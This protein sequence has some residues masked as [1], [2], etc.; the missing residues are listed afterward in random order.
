[1]SLA[2]NPNPTC[3]PAAPAPEAVSGIITSTAPASSR[4]RCSFGDPLWIAR[5]RSLII[6]ALPSLVATRSVDH[7]VRCTDE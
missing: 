3:E 1:M 7:I 6:D 5:E 2:L 4:R